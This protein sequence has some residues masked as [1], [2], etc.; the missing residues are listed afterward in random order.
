MSH[1]FNRRLCRNRQRLTQ[2]AFLGMLPSNL[3]NDGKETLNPRRLFESLEVDEWEVLTFNPDIREVC[4][5][6]R[7]NSGERNVSV[8]IPAS[9]ISPS[10]FNN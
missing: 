10:T 4:L 8:T 9:A 2:A 5:V 1:Q 7:T 6:I 3:D